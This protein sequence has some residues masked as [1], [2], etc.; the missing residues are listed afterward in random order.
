MLSGL[1]SISELITTRVCLGLIYSQSLEGMDVALK[2]LLLFCEEL[3]LAE[4][5]SLCMLTE[6]SK[7]QKTIY[8]VIPLYRKC[9]GKANLL[10][11]ESN[12]LAGA[13][14]MLLTINVHKGSDWNYEN[15]L[16]L[17][18]VMVAQLGKF[19]KNL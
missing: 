15:F 10:E 14:V 8:F 1:L 19:T 2:S 3:V 11:S 7:T 12:C 17:D 18:M 6:R 4:V 5:L 16:Q 13:G 9:P